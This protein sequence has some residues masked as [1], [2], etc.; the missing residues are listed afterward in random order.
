MRRTRAVILSTGIVCLLAIG[1]F[2]GSRFRHRR[3]PIAKAE[4]VKV[5][6]DPNRIVAMEKVAP[7]ALPEIDDDPKSPPKDDQVTFKLP[8]SLIEEMGLG[9]SLFDVQDA[10]INGVVINSKGGF[11][12]WSCT[13]LTDYWSEIPAWG[14]TV[15]KGWKITVDQ[16]RTTRTSGVW[17]S[18]PQIKVINRASG[19]VYRVVAD[20]DIQVKDFGPMDIRPTGATVRWHAPVRLGSAPADAEHHSP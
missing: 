5:S 18:N 2:Y 15:R 1:L 12:N 8:K 9:S 13:G 10:S 17:H 6:L 3:A 19:D 14:K 4:I 7:S 11:I 20:C 16:T